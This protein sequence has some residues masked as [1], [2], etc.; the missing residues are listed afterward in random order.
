MPLSLLLL[1]LPPTPAP[2]PPP[3]LL[4]ADKEGPVGDA[5]SGALLW[6]SAAAAE[7]LLLALLLLRPGLS[8]IV[9]VLCLTAANVCPML[10][11]TNPH[12]VW[13]TASASRSQAVNGPSRDHQA[14]MQHQESQQCCN[15][16]NCRT[17][18]PGAHMPRRGRRAGDTSPESKPKQLRA[19]IPGNGYG[20]Q[21]RRPMQTCSAGTAP[22]P[23]LCSSPALQLWLLHLCR[24]STQVCTNPETHAPHMT[25][26][27]TVKKD[28]T[29]LAKLIQQGHSHTTVVPDMASRSS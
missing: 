2:K 5:T 20:M 29:T 3:A 1:P 6:G 8:R 17:T 16:H 14:Q 27:A 25:K 10:T 24:I 22:P 12:H 11:H 28:I 23:Q 15:Y 18:P 19:I 9:H 13:H 7:M 21:K 26:I 4:P